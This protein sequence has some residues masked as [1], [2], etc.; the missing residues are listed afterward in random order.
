MLGIRNLDLGHP[1]L[2]HVPGVAAV[3]FEGELHVLGGHRVAVVEF[4]AL[5]QDKIVGEAVLGCRPGLGEARR[6]RLTGHRLH[7]RVVQGVQHHKRGNDPRRLRRVEPRRGKCGM[8]APGQL[9][10]RDG[11]KGRARHAGDQAERGKYKE[12]AAS[13]V[14]LSGARTRFFALADG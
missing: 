10:L 8:D 5:P 14:G 11:G 1:V 6:Q 7:D 9:P 13:Q 4:H 2:H 12:V 3:A